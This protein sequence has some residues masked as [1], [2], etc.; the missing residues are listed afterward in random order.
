MLKRQNELLGN[1]LY[2]NISTTRITD[3]RATYPRSKTT[4]PVGT[5]HG[6]I[7]S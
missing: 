7:Q 4:I 1:L 3:T 5:T 6:S 2:K